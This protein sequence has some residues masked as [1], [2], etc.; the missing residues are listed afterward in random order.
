MPEYLLPV[1]LKCQPPLL[2]AETFRR[3][4]LHRRLHLALERG[5]IL[6]RGGPG[7]G[8]TVLLSSFIQDCSVPAVWCTLDDLDQDPVQLLSSLTAALHRVFPRKGSRLPP[9]LEH[10]RRPEQEW[11]QVVSLLLEELETAGPHLLVLDDVHALNPAPASGQILDAILRYLPAHTRLLLAA[12]QRPR[13]RWVVRQRLS[14]NLVEIKPEE[15]LFT[16][17]ECAAWAEQGFRVELSAGEIETLLKYT[18]GWPIG[19][20][21]ALQSLS[22]DRRTLERF[23]GWEEELF[24]YLVV[25]VLDQQ[26]PATRDFLL[27]TSLLS[28]LTPAVCDALL[29]RQDSARR[30]TRLAEEGYFVTSLGQQTYSYHAQFREF[31]YQ[32]L[33]EE[34]PAHRM[35]ELHRRAADFYRTQGEWGE[36]VFHYAYAEQVEPLVEIVRVQGPA[37]LRSGRYETLSAWLNWVPRPILEN[38]PLLLLYEGELM[39]RKEMA[40]GIPTLQ[41]ARTAALQQGDATTAALALSALGRAY[42]RLKEY[43]TADRILEQSFEEMEQA[44]VDDLEARLFHALIRADLGKGLRLAT[45]KT[46]AVLERARLVGEPYIEARA[47]ATLAAFY[48]YLAQLNRCHRAVERV[49]QL[50]STHHLGW[51]LLLQV[52]NIEGYAFWAEGRPEQALAVLRAG[53][54]VARE[55]HPDFRCW[56]TLTTANVLRDLGSPEA[57]VY[58]ERAGKL[59][60]DA[61]DRAEVLAEKAWWSFLQGDLPEACRLATEARSLAEE[62]QGAYM[63]ILSGVLAREEGRLEDSEKLLGQA[64]R[65]SQNRPLVYMALLHRSYTRWLRGDRARAL[66]DLHRAFRLGEKA[67]LAGGY[68]WQPEVVARLCVL[69]LEQRVCPAYAERLAAERLDFRHAGLFLPLLHHPEPEVRRQVAAIVGRIGEADALPSLRLIASDSDERVAEV[70]RQSV[71]RL[72]QGIRLHIYCLGRLDLVRRGHQVEEKEWDPEGKVGRWRVQTLFSYLLLRGSRG[73]SREDLIALLWPGHHGRRAGAV[74]VHK[75]VRA[76]RRVLEPDLERPADSRFLLL[77]EGRY[78]LALDRGVWLDVEEFRQCI[79][80]GRAME[81]SGRS[82]EAL[83]AYR[84][85]VE[86]Y[87]GGYLAGAFREA[88]EE[89]LAD[90]WLSAAADLSEEYWKALRGLERLLVASGRIEEAMAVY[91]GILARPPFGEDIEEAYRAL[92]RL[93]R[94][95]GRGEEAGRLERLCRERYGRRPSPQQNPSR[96]G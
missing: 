23:P 37:L 75:A 52:A 7:Y 2:G 89:V 88:N 93:Y 60:Q 53:L 96:A 11:Q 25:E 95:A 85:A 21:L 44:G 81:R 42:V 29:D 33:C 72:E 39:V 22:L 57:E 49:R 17:E 43:G 78:R 8:K 82:P 74:L 59:A 26:E 14:G 66:H 10:L 94:R 32:K 13:L 51:Q 64:L 55:F 3:E 41:Q 47:L 63:D 24:D 67:G 5:H 38:E 76:L 6:L 69:A 12:R 90:D 9:V 46:E 4:R 87:R 83:A 56:I 19:L 84:R 91:Q 34:F 30:L 1:L 61:S 15:L 48:F 31:L 77:E 35:A 18:Q 92:I 68:F 20:K 71:E 40:R 86:L 70:A 45:R 16:A 65:T 27:A 54:E 58:Y 79:E 73:A 28:Y 36:A 62:I 80:T 50:Q